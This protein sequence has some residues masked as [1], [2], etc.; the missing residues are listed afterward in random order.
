MQNILGYLKQMRYAIMVILLV[1]IASTTLAFY[2]LKQ[3]EEFSTF[4]LQ[5]EGILLSHIL[6]A[7]IVSREDLENTSGLQARIDRFTTSSES[8]IKFIELNIM[9]LEGDGSIIV[10]SN[11][12]GNIEETSEEEHENLLSS[13]KYGKPVVFIG[14]EEDNDEDDENDAHPIS[15]K[16]AS[17]GGFQ[18]EKR[19]LSVTTPLIFDGKG[20]GSI[21]TKLSL[22][23]V[24][25]K[26][27]LIRLSLQIATIIEIVMVLAGFAILVKLF[28]DE[29]VNLLTEESMRYLAELKALQA[30]I[31]PHFLFNTLN[32]LA[33]L[34]SASPERAENLTIEV[35]ELFRKILGASRKGWW[36]LGEE[37]ELIRNYLNIESVRLGKNLKFSISSSQ[38][39]DTIFIPCLVIEPLVENA[40]L[41]GINTSVLG[42]KIVID[43]KG[44]TDLVVI[45][46]DILTIDE[47]YPLSE[48][49]KGENI[50]IKNVCKRLN[51]V[52]G[53]A[54]EL[55]LTTH[56]E[57][58]I[59][60]I[61]IK[62]IR[63]F[64]YGN[65]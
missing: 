53:N 51:L 2:N 19:F 39:L 6:S 46:E 32:S 62:N 54:A 3:F 41:H 26:T 5:R 12:P 29:K 35:S 45:V 55:N 30:Q 61:T 49:S 14:V 13:L 59:A 48:A 17:F 8:N 36:T 22:D 20:L 60:V 23:P 42:G 47:N 38:P 27:G 16:S 7:S 40:I 15:D 10:A 4:N 37:L 33:S 64:K 25:E 56:Q 1:I 9:L 58:A 43:I 24:D 63:S 65:V 28:M 52:Y 34:I 18:K 11:E 44:D 31:N 50:G 21:N 57:G